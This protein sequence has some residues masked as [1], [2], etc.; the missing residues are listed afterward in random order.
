MFLCRL[1]T[2]PGIV[3]LIVIGLGCAR[4]RLVHRRAS[5]VR[6]VY[7]GRYCV[8]VVILGVG[9]IRRDVCGRGRPVARVRWGEC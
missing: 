7:R 9:G 3:L 4:R 5:G 2:L 8:H 6:V 1:L